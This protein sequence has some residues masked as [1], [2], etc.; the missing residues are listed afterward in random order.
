MQFGGIFE[1]SCNQFK[2]HKPLIMKRLFLLRHGEAGFSDGSDFQRQ[3]TK[4]GIENL[5][6][7]GERLNPDLKSIDLMY[8]STATRTTQTAEIIGKYIAIKE[9]IF[10]KDIYN[11]DMGNIIAMLEKTFASVE[12]CLLI[13][14][15][16]TISLLLSHISSENYLGLQPGMMAVLD[17]E[18][19][20]W[21]MIGFGTGT[22]KE[23]IQ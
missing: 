7:M 21:R 2:G 13:G 6:R 1:Q 8:C 14:H 17:L 19:S 23:I 4:K 9:S 18:I 10:T 5:V 3:L 16:P 22:L 12:T 15:N 20:D 11:D